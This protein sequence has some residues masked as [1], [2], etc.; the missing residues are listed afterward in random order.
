MIGRDEQRARVSS[1]ATAAAAT[2][3]VLVLT[4]CAATVP[5]APRPEGAATPGTSSRYA[6]LLTECD[7][8]D[9]DQIAHAVGGGAIDRGF[10][11]AICRWSVAGP[12]GPVRVTFN[13]FETG[14][15]AVERETSHR[16]GYAVE[17]VSVDGRRAVLSRQ[18]Q[19]PGTC[20]IASGAPDS[21]VIGWWVQY[22]AAE[23]PDP[24]EAAATLVKLTLELSA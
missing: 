16:L 11:G 22:Q 10:F 23:H 13:W 2:I 1:I 14:S 7:A 24:C 17:D 18:P 12:A 8:V 20:G 5:G 19:D 15:L 4:G 6:A 3:G 21:G 9:S